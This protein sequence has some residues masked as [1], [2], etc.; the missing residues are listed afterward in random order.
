MFIGLSRVIK[1]GFAGFYRSGWLS[2]ATIFV[3]VLMLFTLSGL[4]L[5]VRS[6]D[7]LLGTLQD[8]VDI[9]VYVFPTVEESRILRMKEQLALLPEVKEVDY[10]SREEALKR[11]REKH[12]ENAV[13]I[14]SL[15]ELGE[16]PLE[17]SLNIRAHEADQFDAIAKFLE[18]DVYK[19]LIDKVNYSQNRDAIQKLA[20]IVSAVRRGGMVVVAILAAIALLVAF[21]TIRMAIYAMREEIGVMRLVGASNWFI[22]GPFLIGG[23]LCG[24]IASTLTLGIW[25]PVLQKFS[26]SFDRVLPG[27][28]LLS[29]YTQHIWFFAGGLLAVS[30]L[31]CV[32][33]SGIAIG[34]YLKV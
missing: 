26:P 23:I 8:K 27:L 5:L 15:D 31:L 13:I 11:F 3:L 9:S 30:I 29:Y 16:N 20:S 10:V 18:K 21:N 7:Y 25:I 2:L 28:H 17:A 1:S 6:A 22:R 4:A 33:S 32:V 12:K 34:R 24:I 14:E 19:P